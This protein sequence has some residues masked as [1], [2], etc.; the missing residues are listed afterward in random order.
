VQPA[1][2]GAEHAMEVI[3]IDHT[4]PDVTVLDRFT[5]KPIDRPW[6]TLAIDLATRLELLERVALGRR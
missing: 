2:F 1:V 4:Q 6:L 3:Q 5:R